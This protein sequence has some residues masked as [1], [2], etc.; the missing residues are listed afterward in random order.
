MFK[1][2]SKIYKDKKVEVITNENKLI[3]GVLKSID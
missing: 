3:K 2:I 1:Q